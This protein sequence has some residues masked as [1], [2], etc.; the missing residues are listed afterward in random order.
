MLHV[1]SIWPILMMMISFIVSSH[2]QT[3][4]GTTRQTFYTTDNKF[5]SE[6]VILNDLSYNL[7]CSPC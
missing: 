4:V 1:V 5:Y 7:L 2:K 6:A 3:N